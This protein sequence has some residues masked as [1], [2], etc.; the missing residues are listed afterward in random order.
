MKI[1]VTGGA[2]FIGYHTTKRLLERGDDVVIVDN[3]NDYYEISLKEARIKDIKK[4][5]SDIRVE[6]I[7]LKDYDELEKVFKRE[8]FDKVC[9]LAAQAG[10]R[11][12]LDFP[13]KYIQSNTIGTLNILELCRHNNVTDLVFASSS[14]VYGNNKKMPFSE[15]DKVDTPISL[16]AAT[17]K[18]N[19]EMA[20]AYHHLFG[21]NCVGLRFFTVYGPW[22]RPDMALSRFTKN[23]L[24]GEPI[25]VYNNGEM[26]RDF[27]YVDD[28]VSGVVAAIDSE[29]KYEIFNLARGESVKLMDY[30]A[31]IEKN[32][33]KEAKKNMMPM[34]PGD[35]PATS[36]DIS[37][38][39]KLLDYKPRPSVDEGIKNFIEWYM[40][41]YGV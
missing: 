1:L 27:T 33:G 17:K 39:Q 15:E 22:N 20:F 6:R 10:V 2:G 7:N 19:E 35:V 8:K 14:S 21:L 5:N 12:S 28:I 29:L 36:A 24:C 40:S 32:L 34:Q 23:I 11:Y 41:Y 9:H 31:E 38:A 13:H 37:K 25:D 16:Y 18:S 26:Y 30:I 3:F 4:I